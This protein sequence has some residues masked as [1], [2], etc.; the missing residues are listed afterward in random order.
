M[1]TPHTRDDEMTSEQTTPEETACHQEITTGATGNCLL[2]VEHVCV[3]ECN[4]G[5][6]FFSIHHASAATKSGGAVC[7]LKHSN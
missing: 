4:E 3:G 6:L 5:L 1:M 7:K 2:N